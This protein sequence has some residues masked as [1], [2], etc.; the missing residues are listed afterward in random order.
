M[1]QK[2]SLKGTN[3]GFE[4][5]SEAKF[6]VLSMRVKKNTNFFH[7]ISCEGFTKERSEITHKKIPFLHAFC[8]DL[9]FTYFNNHFSSSIFQ[10]TEN[11]STCTCVT[12]QHHVEWRED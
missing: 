12:Q 10:Q 11:K 9:S 7:F 5:K 2:K 6:G 8:S 3:L 1:M 4:K